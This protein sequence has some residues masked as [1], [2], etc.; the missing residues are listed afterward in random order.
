MLVGLVTADWSFAELPFVFFFRQLDPVRHVLQ[1]LSSAY[2]YTV[3]AAVAVVAVVA[4]DTFVAAFAAF[5][6]DAVVAATAPG[7]AFAVVAVVAV[8]A[9]T[10]PGAAFAVVA[11]VAVVAA[12]AATVVGYLHLDSR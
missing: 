11:V 2:S 6:V 7:A 10:A 8:I 9:A 5:A 1:F 3:G 4:V 12:D